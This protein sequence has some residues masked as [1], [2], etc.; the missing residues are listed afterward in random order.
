VEN[1][2]FVGFG[3]VEIDSISG[4]SGI[5]HDIIRPYDDNRDA[6]VIIRGYLRKNQFE[7]MIIY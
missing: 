1:G 3:Y 6:H 5:L 7:K 2:R 4:S